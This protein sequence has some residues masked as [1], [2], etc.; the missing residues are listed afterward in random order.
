MLGKDFLSSISNPSDGYYVTENRSG[1]K[2]KWI[3]GEFDTLTSNN[4]IDIEE[5]RPDILNIGFPNNAFRDIWDDRNDEKNKN[6]RIFIKFP[7]NTGNTY[8]GNNIFPPNAID[9]DMNI[10]YL[11]GL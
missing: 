3:F 2:Y 5:I 10:L 8:F 9:D 4:T 1:V 11:D 7:I 6:N